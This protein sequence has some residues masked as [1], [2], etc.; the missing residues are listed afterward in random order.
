MDGYEVRPLHLERTCKYLSSSC[1]Y[2]HN[3]YSIVGTKTPPKKT[4]SW[5]VTR[6]STF[7]HNFCNTSNIFILINAID[8]KH[9][10]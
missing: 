4:N 10:I 9:N 2:N 5:S 3:S 1:T 8:F 7:E 6:F